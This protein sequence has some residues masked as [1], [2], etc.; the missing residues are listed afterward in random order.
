MRAVTTHLPNGATAHADRLDRAIARIDDFFDGIFAGLEQWRPRLQRR[1]TDALRF[2]A[3]TG[4]QLTDLIEDDVLGILDDPSR[5]LYGAGY[6][7]DK[8]VVMTGSPLA[9]WQ[10]PDRTLLASSTFGTAQAAVDMARFE[11]Y[12]VPLSSGRQHVAGPFVD[13]LCSNEITVT[14]SLPLE[15]HGR[16]SGVMCADVLV[17]SLENVLLP[18]LGN[19]PGA[20]V[21]NSSGRVAISTHADYETGDRFPDWD[22]DTGSTFGDDAVTAQSHR[23]P[24]AIVIP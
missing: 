4:G 23:H 7:A 6:C 21:I 10:G 20:L 9:W 14:M 2:G 24:F 17:S 16:F 5:P 18:E 22:A 13:Y 11:W 8:N 3:L 15:V 12:R 1:L 19:L